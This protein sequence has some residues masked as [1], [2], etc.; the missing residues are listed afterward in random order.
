MPSRPAALAALLLPALAAAAEPPLVIELFEDDARTMLAQLT[1]GGITGGE[2]NAA[3][4]EAD[5]VFSGTTALRV[6]ATQRFC[7]DIKGWDFAIA[8]KPKPGEFR[9]LR[10][11]WKKAAPGGP[12]MLQFHTRKPTADW[13]VRYYMGPGPPWESKVLAPVG[14]GEWVVVTRDLFKD[15]GPATLGGIAFSPL[16]GGD[17]LFDHVLLGRT[18]EDLDRATAAA[19]LKT[20]PRRPVTAGRLKQLWTDLGSPDE[21]TAASAVWAL[22]AR[23]KEA[24]PFLLKSAAVPDRR[25][26]RPV[27]DA[28]VTPLIDRLTHYRYVTRAAAEEELVRLGNGVLPHLR[29]A[30][31]AAEGERKARLTA[32][33]DGWAARTGFDEPRLRRAATVLRTVGTPEAKERAAAIEKALP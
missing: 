27:D 7:P 4:A 12:I 6:A 13:N 19:L 9:Y 29:K 24:V 10:F 23:R 3:S 5:D 33:L 21:I 15:F 18:V 26:P 25:P 28:T 11:A 8:E 1:H 2:T 17:G 16:E 20:T 32:I 31:E 14:P 22:V 30:A